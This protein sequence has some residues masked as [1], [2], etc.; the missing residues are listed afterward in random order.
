M[1]DHSEK[2]MLLGAEIIDRIG[3]ILNGI[4]QQFGYAIQLDNAFREFKNSQCVDPRYLEAAKGNIA[5]WIETILERNEAFKRHLAED[6]DEDIAGR[7]IADKAFMIGIDFQRASDS[8]S[9]LHEI[10]KD[11]AFEKRIFELYHSRREFL[12]ESKKAE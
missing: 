6:F 1:S 9:K 12:I 10:L 11:G 5:H 2:D 4:D 7:D 8:E 3:L